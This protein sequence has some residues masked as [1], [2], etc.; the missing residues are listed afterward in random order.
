LAELKSAER[1]LAEL[2]SAELKSLFLICFFVNPA[3]KAIRIKVKLVVSMVFSFKNI[4]EY[5]YFL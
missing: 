3:L 1:K 5:D 2:K 4:K